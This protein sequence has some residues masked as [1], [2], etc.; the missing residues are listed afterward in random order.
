MNLYDSYWGTYSV[1]GVAW[2]GD[3]SDDCQNSRLPNI[4]TRVSY[5]INWIYNNTDIVPV[6]K[7]VTTTTTT[8]TT[9]VTDVPTPTNYPSQFDCK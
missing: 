2:M 8:T 5:Y 4:Y 3:S 6:P 1:V 7:P 9:S